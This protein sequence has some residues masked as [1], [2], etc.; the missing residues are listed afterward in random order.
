LAGYQPVEANR[1][2][3]ER[4]IQ[5]IL[6]PA[7]NATRASVAQGKSESAL[8]TYDLDSQLQVRYQHIDAVAKLADAWIS[9]LSHKVRKSNSQPRQAIWTKDDT[10]PSNDSRPVVTV[11]VGHEDDFNSKFAAT[12]QTLQNDGYR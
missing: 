2:V 8:T 1:E 12:T 11:V 5:S 4:Y 10:N 3:S 6:M 9:E 7:V